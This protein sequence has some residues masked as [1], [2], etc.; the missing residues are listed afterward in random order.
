MNASEGAKLVVTYITRPTVLAERVGHGA[1]D[2]V[3]GWF[4]PE[5]RSRY[6]RLVESVRTRL[7]GLPAHEL[8]EAERVEKILSTA[9][10]HFEAVGLTI[11][12][13]IRRGLD[14]E[15]A[16]AAQ[17]DRFD[18]W[19]PG[20][21]SEVGPICRGHVIPAVFEAVFADDGALKEIDLAFKRAVLAQR[22]EIRKIPGAV[23]DAL[24]AWLGATLLKDPAWEWQAGMA[25]SALLQAEFAV[26]PFEPREELLDGAKAWCDGPEP[27]GIRLYVGPG[28]MGKTRLLMQLCR[29]LDRSGW[30]TGFLESLSEPLAAW[31]AETIFY[32]DVRTLVVVDYAENRSDDVAVLLEHA[33]KRSSAGRR[34]RIALLARGEADWWD[35]LRR[36]TALAH[37]LL[38][39]RITE[40][41]IAVGAIAMDEVT[42]LRCFEHALAAFAAR[43]GRKP[44]RLAVKPDLSG[45]HFGAVL[46]VHMSA[47]ATIEGKS[48][49]TARELHDFMLDREARTW[50]RCLVGPKLSQLDIDD[51]LQAMAMIV[52]AGGVEGLGEAH[53]LVSRA[54]RLQHYPPP[55]IDDLVRLLA[56]LYPRIDRMVGG[57]DL[58]V[59]PLRPDILGERLIERALQRDPRLLEAVFA[60]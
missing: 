2:R 59:E 34:V 60:G 32:A 6:E 9:A 15:A 53:A 13:L 29:D 24:K 48:L 37:A 26:V 17:Q 18:R 5:E 58:R 28:G 47:L 50:Q 21:G 19:V 25:D 7:E 38:S 33:I 49:G 55:T 35:R 27:L 20:Q 22:D 30:R 14:Q 4:G 57:Q 42:R 1:I 11:D 56:R 45:E 16:I 12:D 54:P 31:S 43:L 10:A 36:S 44:R 46:M 41:A 8:G 52:F 40:P 39:G 3:V 23:G 51:V